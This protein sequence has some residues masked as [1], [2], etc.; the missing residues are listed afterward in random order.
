MP[1]MHIEG[2]A[3][4]APPNPA[5]VSS[6]GDTEMAIAA[7][8]A[9]TPAGQPARVPSSCAAAA[10]ASESSSV[11]QTSQSQPSTTE[12]DANFGHSLYFIEHLFPSKLWRILDDAERCGYDNVIS[13]VD[14]GMSFQIRK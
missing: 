2:G 10:A 12:N 7:A 11:A 4:R 14:N 1:T 9:T 3:P 8:A 5:A 6:S 13:W